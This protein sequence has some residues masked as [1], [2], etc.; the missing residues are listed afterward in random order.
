MRAQELR[1]G[2]EET[3]QVGEFTVRLRARCERGV[4]WRMSQLLWVRV[5][6]QRQASVA[7]LEP[8]NHEEGGYRRTGRLVQTVNSWPFQGRNL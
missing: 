1:Y 2:N 3:V 6:T 7:T 4:A 8:G 5:T